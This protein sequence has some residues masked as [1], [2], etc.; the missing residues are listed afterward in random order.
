M[1]FEQIYESSEELH[2]GKGSD[3]SVQTI[4]SQSM[5]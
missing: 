4:L 1:G 3:D 2:N 5:R